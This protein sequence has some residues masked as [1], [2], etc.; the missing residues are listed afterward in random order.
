MAIPHYEWVRT[1][2]LADLLCSVSDVPVTNL[3]E[4]VENAG[5]PSAR[6][7]RRILKGRCTDGPL[8]NTRAVV[9]DAALTA[10][11]AP[12]AFYELEVKVG[13]W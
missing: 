11:N 2:D 1:R 3:P 4:R 8:R 5:G 7:I 10:L 12:H 13:K 9:A 6:Q